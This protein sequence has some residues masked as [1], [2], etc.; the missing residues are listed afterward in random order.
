MLK[1]CSKYR[2]QMQIIEP[3]EASFHKAPLLRSN[4]RKPKG[5]YIPNDNECGSDVYDK[6]E[7]VIHVEH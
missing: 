3:E 5:K 7:S 4:V 2:Y 6:W 1:Y